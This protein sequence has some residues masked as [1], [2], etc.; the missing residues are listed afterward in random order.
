MKNGKPGRDFETLILLTW[1]ETNE[2]NEQESRA[3][4]K[5]AFDIL[6]DFIFF[7]T[8]NVEIARDGIQRLFLGPK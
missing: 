1:R 3:R 4:R 8:N 7:Y 6:M 5:E 2:P